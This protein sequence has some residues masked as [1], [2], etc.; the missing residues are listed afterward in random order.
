[1]YLK[2]AGADVSEEIMAS[3]ISIEV[4]DNLNLPDTFTI[5]VRD[6]K[7]EW[8]DSDTFALGKSVEISVRGENGP[9]KLVEGEFTALEPRFSRSA[10]PCLIAR[11][12]DKSHRL[13]REKKTQS[14]IQ[15]TDSDIAKKIADKARLRSKADAT[16][17]VHEY[18]LQDNQSDWEF[19]WD[20]AQRIGYRVYVEGDELHFRKAPDGAAGPPVLEW[21]V[22][23]IE[24]SPRLSTSQQ[25]SEV[26]VR[27]WDPREKKEIVG[28]A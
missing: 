4:D 8:V 11:G 19:L 3:L 27:G 18:V 23:L 13:N 2:V 12:Y 14:F 21:G 6:P 16:R 20:R 17:E 9:V 25:V 1:M 24:F 28:R 7:L 5:H 10:G 15:S 26:I 22:N